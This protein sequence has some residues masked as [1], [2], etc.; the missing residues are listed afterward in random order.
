MAALSASSV[1]ESLGHRS[2]VV[3]G[4][5]RDA[6]LC[7]DSGEADITTSAGTGDI[8]LAWPGSAVIGR[9]PDASVIIR[10]EGFLIDVSSFRGNDLEKDLGMR[11]L[12]VNSIAMT[13]DGKIIDPWGGAADIASR[14]LRFTRDPMERLREDPLRG[15]RIA[16]FA[17]L[18]DGFSI[19]ER[20]CQACREFS[21]EVALLPGTR[22][23]KEILHALEGD[24]P[25]FLVSLEMLGI[26]EPVFPFL[27][28]APSGAR[29]AVLGRLNLAGKKTMDPAVRAACLMADTGNSVRGIVRSWGWPRP[30][31]REV[32]NLV[33]NRLFPSSEFDP[34]MLANHFRTGGKSWINRLFLFGLIDCLN[35]R[36]DLT[37]GW[38]GNRIKSLRSIVRLEKM[39]G[40]YS[41]EEIMAVM[42]L[43][44]GQAVGEVIAQLEEAISLGSV[45][46]RDELLLWLSSRKNNCPDQV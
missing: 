23:G 12:T 30:L 15:V 24:L 44:S 29:T 32:S 9:Q 36:P 25:H 33:I 39:K 42:G 11:D 21:K 14:V 13:P 4:A 28:E 1:L 5:I 18:L 22:I 16:R 46:D 38:A 45:A 7:R 43:E 34:G 26:L 40:T 35:G 8:L 31:A 2:A 20:S 37:D 41:G 27:A 3:G 6:I 19:D 10:H 17:S